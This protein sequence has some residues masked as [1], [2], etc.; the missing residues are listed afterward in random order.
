VKIHLEGEKDH[1]E[2]ERETRKCANKMNNGHVIQQ[3]F[4]PFSCFFLITS[5]KITN[6][7]VRFDCLSSFV[8][9]CRNHA[10]QHWWVTLQHT[11]NV[12]GQ[13]TMAAVGVQKV[14][15]RL[16]FAVISLR[17]PDVGEPR[18]KE[19]QTWEIVVWEIKVGHTMKKET[20]KKFRSG[21]GK[22]VLYNN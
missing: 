8:S 5:Q 17:F 14:F 16:L 22:F 1:H 10:A 18:E 3:V 6:K 15:W 12:G 4:F 13:L 7:P 2:A 9:V 19:N 11:G 20:K 21:G